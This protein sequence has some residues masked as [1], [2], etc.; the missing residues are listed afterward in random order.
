MGFY[1]K[2][3]TLTTRETARLPKYWKLRQ[4]L[5]IF[6][7]SNPPGTLLPPERQLSAEFELSRTT[8]RKAIKEL[9]VEGWLARVQG[10]GNFVAQP[11]LAHR[12]RLNSSSDDGVAQ[13]H[14]TGSRLVN[15]EVVPA[16]ALVAA[17]LAINPG[18][19]VFRVERLRTMDGEP[20]AIDV[21]FVSAERFP[22]VLDAVAR[23]ESLYATLANEYG[24]TTAYA[25]ETVET[26]VANP[27]DA[28]L[29]NAEVGLPLLVLTRQ[30]F[31]ASDT[32]I[33]WAR[34]A[35]RGDRYKFVARRID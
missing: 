25:E 29:L 13:G 28:H 6:A 8:V 22:G 14:R 23:H 27:D 21:N 1:E 30:A 10:R 12:L 33:E 20:M 18:G 32:P 4:W 35:F 31:D 16:T 15:A 2:G 9:I 34:S 11:K 5:L 17:A 19:E 26:G 7:Q 3:S 24:V